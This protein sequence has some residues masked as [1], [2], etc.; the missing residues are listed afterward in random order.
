M[1]SAWYPYHKGS[2][3]YTFDLRVKTTDPAL[4]VSGNAEVS[5]SAGNWRLVETEPTSDMIVVAAPKM[6]TRN[7]EVGG[8]KLRI[9]S[10]SASDAAV[11]QLARDA[12]DIVAHYSRWYGPANLRTARFVLNPRPTGGGYVRPRFMSLPYSADQMTWLAHEIGHFWWTGAQADSWKDWLN[13]SFAAYSSVRYIREVKGEKDYEAQVQAARKRSTG[14]PPI[15][16]I[17]RNDRNAHDVLYDKGALRML[18][19]EETIGQDKF[20]NFLATLHHDRIKNTAALLQTLEKQ[21]TAEVR[22]KF[23]TMLKEQ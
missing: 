16:G 15:W 3:A 19:L 17:S 5:G 23:E 10:A 21:T 18:A 11:E 12:A 13:E 8:L 2:G 9:D 1:Y 6:T 20:N 4:K 14:K 7:Q 22:Q